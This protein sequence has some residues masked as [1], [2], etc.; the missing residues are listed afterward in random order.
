MKKIKHDYH[1]NKCGYEWNKK[2]K[3]KNTIPKACPFCKS[4]KWAE[5]P[6]EEK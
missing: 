5:K 3:F 6:K 4:Y 1:C 2:S